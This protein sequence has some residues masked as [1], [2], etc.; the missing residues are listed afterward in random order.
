M[1]SRIWTADALSSE[2]RPLAGEAW[3]LVEAQH[4]VSTLKL[5]DDW[6]EQGLLEE[7]LEQTK[8]PV[9]AGCRGL[10]FL[11]SSPFRYDAEYP[12]GS[13]FRRAGRTP[14]V[15]YAAEAVATAVAE[16][17]FYRLLFFADS[18]D[19]PLPANPGEY[20]AFGVLYGTDD[21]LDLTA[22]PLN[23][24]GACWTHPTEYVA[25]QDL[26]EAARASGIQA[27]RYLSI[28]DPRGGAN[29]ALL[30]CAAFRKP[31]PTAW[32]SWRLFL[33]RDSVQALCEFPH[34]TLHFEKSG[35]NDPR[36]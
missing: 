10:H 1:S 24:E 29:L 5:V 18:P 2:R 25:C 31:E 30:E 9:P 16:L 28:R 6:Q 26:A 23:G 34:Q 32:Q 22:E 19:T 13:R 27:I 17:A 35:F 8:P 11:L 12:V 3:R 14:G 15:F 36:L 4:K 33:R 20:T 21:G 7:L